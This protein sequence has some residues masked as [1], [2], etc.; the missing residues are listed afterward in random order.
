MGFIAPAMPWII[1][2]ASMLGGYIASKRAQKS[3]MQRSPEEQPALGGAQ[4]AASD[5]TRTGTA[6]LRGGLDLLRTG[7]QTT[8]G[9]TD[10]YQTL[11]RGNRAAQAQAT[12]APRGAISDVYTGA[13]RG[14]EKSGV[15]GAA[16]DV[17]AGELQREKAGKISSLVTGVQPGAA[18][19]LTGIGATQTG[20][21]IGMAGN[22][23]SAYGGAGS[24]YSNLLGQGMYNRQYG[25]QEGEKA[26]SKIGSFLFDIMKGVGK[27]Y[28]GG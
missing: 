26:G 19:A 23:G 22:A 9:P 1:K 20:Q 16:R 7:E 6:Q 14:L 17:A 25:R 4:G 3:A 24:L 13:E 15:R 11:L 5:L 18:E 2:G 10:Y 8:A 28:S 27:K 21:G 12:A